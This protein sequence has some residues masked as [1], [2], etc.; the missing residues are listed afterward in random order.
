LLSNDDSF[1]S[2]TSAEVIPEVVPK[3]EAKLY[4]AGV[5][6]MGRGPKLIYR[7]SDDIFEEPS[8]PEA[9][10]RLMRIIAV[11]DDHEFGQNGMWD[12]VRDQVRGPLVTHQ[13]LD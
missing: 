11:P 8:G 13:F 12:R 4:Y 5:G 6:L 7:T 9:Y 1:S 2:G 10:K 3:I